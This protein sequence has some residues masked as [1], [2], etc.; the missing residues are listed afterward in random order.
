MQIPDSPPDFTQLMN[1]LMNNNPNLFNKLIRNNQL[2]DEKGRYL[3]W[4][5]LQ[6]REPPE[7]LTKEYWWLSLKLA[8]NMMY[9]VLPINNLGKDKFKYNLT[10]KINRQLH[11]IDINASGSMTIENPILTPQMSNTYIISSLIEESITSSQLEGAATTRKI[12]KKMIQEGRKPKTRSEQMIFNNY[13][14][15]KFIGEIKNEKLTPEL[16]RKIHK[17]LTVNTLDNENN[18]GKYRSSEENI[19]VV[20][21]TGLTLFTPPPAKQIQSRIKELCAFANDLSENKKFIH[22]VIQSIL[23]HF[24]LSYI[25]PF[26]DG[27][28]RTA[29]ALFY[30]SMLNKGYWVAEF[31]SISNILKKAPAKYGYSFLY[32]ET[33]SNDLTYFIDYQ[34]DVIDRA[35]QEFKKYVTRKINEIQSIEKIL[36][37][38][39]KLKKALNSRQNSLIKHALR[40]PGYLYSIKEHQ[41]IHGITYETAR[42][43][44]LLLSDEFDLFIKVKEGKSFKFISPM[45]LAERIEEKN[46]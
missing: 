4:D 5:E 38:N 36:R 32:T 37:K 45:D 30:W 19:Q 46:Q 14:A 25:H 11:N 7:G 27:N 8:R 26:I 10:D 17:I 12:A 16:I 44:L 29:R 6:Y 20:D 18:A 2:T 41:N 28:G 1:D 15:M 22:P 24:L 31:I 3:P 21:G 13:I 33:D 43:D 23:T 40:H 34:L 35:I 9:T 39:Q 42:K